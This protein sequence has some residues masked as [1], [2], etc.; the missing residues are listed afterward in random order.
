MKRA[1]RL[2]LHYTG[3]SEIAA[4][5]R[6]GHITATA[7][8]ALM[9]ERIDKLN[10][11]LNAFVA[12]VAEQA[13]DAAGSADERLRRGQA[14][15]LLDGIPVAI[16]DNIE[17]RGI[18]TTCGSR[19]Y[20]DQ[21]PEEDANVVQRL[22]AVGAII[23][24]KTGTHELAYGTTSINP[25][26]GR[27]A[28]PWDV[29]RDP[30]GSSGG[31]ACAVAAGLAFAAL[32][33]DTACSIRYPAH[34]C[35]VVGF[36]PSF[37]LVGTS[38]VLPLVR[39]MD[40]IGPLTRSVEDAA[41]VTQAIA[42]PD[43]G[44]PHSS[45]R[46]FTRL[47]M[48]LGSMS[49]IRLGIARQFFFDG[50]REIIEIVT[51]GLDRLERQGA[52]IVDID[53]T[54]LEA[55]LEMSGIIF[56]EAYALHAEALA[57]HP[58]DF[59]PELQGKLGRKSRISA[60]DYIRAQHARL[61]FKTHM[62]ELMQ[63]CD[64]L[65]APTATIMPAPFDQRPDGYDTHASKNATVFNLSG[66]PSISIPCGVNAAGLPVGMMI[67]GRL[68]HDAELLQIASQVENVLAMQDLHPALT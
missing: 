67:S 20:A 50:D 66:Q 56:A 49:G 68:D 22:K 46:Q 59:S 47:D 17:T 52:V 63:R 25:F 37:G 44:D 39:T 35:G 12:V 6:S 9:L 55:S 61:R 58:E 34:C 1:D 16:K 64:V 32:G 31:S 10:P 48:D 27:I 43:A 19:L 33:S 11:L 54:G 18:R 28:N 13:L 23:L 7:L 4:L 51:R 15:G 14:L 29:N 2:A 57:A 36:K 45:G 53:S 3:I 8:T 38:G 30:G 60:A 42:G 41:I 24:G 26:F 62:A 65:V 21:V 5:L 40:H